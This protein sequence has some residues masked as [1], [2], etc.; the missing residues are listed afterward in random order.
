MMA[1]K[2]TFL[3]LTPSARDCCI[4][5]LY[6][7]NFISLRTIVFSVIILSQTVER[8]L[9]DFPRL[10]LNVVQEVQYF[11]VFCL[12]FIN[13]VL[14]AKNRLSFYI[15]LLTD[16]PRTFLYLNR[17]RNLLTIAVW[18]S[19]VF[20]RKISAALFYNYTILFSIAM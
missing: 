1:E 18:S 16:W 10:R 15:N 20:S 9:T 5:V 11:L 8:Y 14:F 2:S 13:T 19:T 6:A 17:I 7:N 4:I 3:Y 12:L